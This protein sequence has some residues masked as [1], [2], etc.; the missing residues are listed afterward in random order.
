M[1]FSAVIALG[2]VFSRKNRR[3]DIFQLRSSH[4]FSSSSGTAPRVFP[5]QGADEFDLPDGGHAR[6]ITIAAPLRLRRRKAQVFEKSHERLEP[7]NVQFGVFHEAR[8]FDAV[9]HEMAQFGVG[10]D[11]DGVPRPVIAG[12]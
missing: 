5:P 12:V 11:P 7:V 2:A 8:S 1:A 4:L 6:P 9:R 3:L 10:F